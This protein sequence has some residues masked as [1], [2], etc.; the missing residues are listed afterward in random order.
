MLGL[1]TIVLILSIVALIV[2]GGVRMANSEE[3]WT[4][5]L[6]WIDDPMV[7][8]E[9]NDDYSEYFGVE[10]YI[11]IGN[12]VIIVEYTTDLD[13]GW[14]TEREWVPGEFGEYAA[15]LY[16]SGDVAMSMSELVLKLDELGREALWI[17][18]G[19]AVETRLYAFA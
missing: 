9:Y 15:L 8:I 11:T 5:V 2:V 4:D 12:R 17:E 10:E 1:K 18:S 19:G 14:I 6:N 16:D 3:A 7:E 13:G